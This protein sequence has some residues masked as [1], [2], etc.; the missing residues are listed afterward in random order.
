LGNQPVEVGVCWTL[1][2]QRAAANVIHSLIVKHDSNI[3]VLQQRV[4]GQH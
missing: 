4:G 1:N 3:S 2:V